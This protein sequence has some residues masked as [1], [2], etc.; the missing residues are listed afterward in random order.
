MRGE[1][2]NTATRRSNN[3]NLLVFFFCHGKSANSYKMEKRSVA[4]GCLVYIILHSVMWLFFN[5][6]C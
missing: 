3:P 2:G 4:L 5:K 1:G 6:P